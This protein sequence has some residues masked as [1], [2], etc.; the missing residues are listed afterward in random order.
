MSKI[1]LYHTTI[2]NG[3]SLFENT[4]LK[5]KS[6]DKYQMIFDTHTPYRDTEYKTITDFLF[7]EIF[8]QWKKSCLDYY[9]DDGPSLMEDKTI[10]KKQINAFDMIL[11]EYVLDA[12]LKVD[13]KEHTW[14]EFK[15][16]IN[17]LILL[18]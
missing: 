11:S 7:C 13:F 2:L 8:P 12:L 10:T 17:E 14:E 6:N 5:L 18:G 3:F 9:Y 15:I 16:T 1:R 4:I